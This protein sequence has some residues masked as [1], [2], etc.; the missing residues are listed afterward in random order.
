[1]SKIWNTSVITLFPEMFPGPLS[2][3]LAG[4]A[5]QKTWELDIIDLKKYG[6][7]KYNKV[8]DKPYGGGDGLLLKADVVDKAVDEALKKE[9]REIIFFTP[10]GKK[11]TQK[12][13]KNFA[14]QNGVIVVCGR[15]EGLDS[16]V[17]KKYNMQEFSVCD[18]VLSGG[19]IACLSFLD[20]CVRMLEGTLKNPNV[21]TCESFEEN[22]LEHEQYTKPAVWQD[23]EVPKVLLSG[24]QAAI[25][26]WR[27]ESSIKRTKE[28][29]EDL[30]KKYI[31]GQKENDK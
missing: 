26:K 27:R 3:S 13:I 24:D 15:Y 9:K 14:K 29:R 18:Y 25:K 20:A 22:L 23:L 2:F 31:E 28:N 17:I 19:E 8:D 7:G 1:M 4:K 6:Q 5:L 16:R 12:N 30:Y 10:S 21:L 11:L